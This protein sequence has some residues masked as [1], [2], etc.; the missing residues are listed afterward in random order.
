MRQNLY[1]VI[2]G[3][4]HIIE[5]NRELLGHLAGN[6]AGTSGNVTLAD[7]FSPFPSLDGWTRLSNM[8]SPGLRDFPDSDNWVS[9]LDDCSIERTVVYLTACLAFGLI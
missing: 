4:G 1:P 8:N 3:N 7:T 9:F 2:N 5:R 6:Y